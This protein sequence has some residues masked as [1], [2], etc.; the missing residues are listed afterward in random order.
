MEQ[1]RLLIVFKKAVNHSFLLTFFAAFGRC[2]LFI[3]LL[4]FAFYVILSKVAILTHTLRVVRL[5]WMAA[6]VGHLAFAAP[7]IAIMAHVFGVV[8]SVLVRTIGDL[9]TF[10]VLILRR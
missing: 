8:L 1:G 10:P 2:R 9:A 7:V 4:L 5:V 6:G 3:I